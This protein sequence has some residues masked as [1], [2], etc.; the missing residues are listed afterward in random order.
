MARRRMLITVCDL[1]YQRI[2]AVALRR[3]LDRN[4]VP[5]SEE[6][7]MWV[8]RR[9]QSLRAT[10]VNSWELQRYAE[11]LADALATPDTDLD[12]INTFIEEHS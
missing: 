2:G 4:P 3:F 5:D 11:R 10:G 7:G 6:M 9:L 8:D 12:L 1:V